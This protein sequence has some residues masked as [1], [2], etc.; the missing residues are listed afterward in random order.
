MQKKAYSISEQTWTQIGPAYQYDMEQYK[1]RPVGDICI[2]TERTPGGDVYVTEP[3][4]LDI[5][6]LVFD[7]KVTV[8]LDMYSDPPVVLEKNGK[9]V[10]HNGDI[11]Y[12]KEQIDKLMDQ[13]SSF[14]E[15]RIWAMTELRKN[16]YGKANIGRTTKVLR[17]QLTVAMPEGVMQPNTKLNYDFLR[18]Y[19]LDR[20]GRSSH[21]ELEQKIQILD[22]NDF[23]NLMGGL[24][25]YR[26]LGQCRFDPL[27][28]LLAE[29]QT[30]S[31]I[32]TAFHMD[33]E[34]RLLIGELK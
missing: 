2:G 16:M 6:P 22:K 28:S 24:Q 31:D 12:L 27:K 8:H 1:G 3:F 5:L 14:E 32:E 33:M 19:L 23:I 4:F 21:N 7:R 13:D 29:G 17:E 26:N 34:R 30:L 25:V 9:I 10:I 15:N 11:A 20:Y 18:L